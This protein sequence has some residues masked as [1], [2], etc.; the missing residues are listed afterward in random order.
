MNRDGTGTAEEMAPGQALLGWLEQV[1]EEMGRDPLEDLRGVR[2]KVEARARA[3]E[4][5]AG[6]IAQ[7]RAAP[8][9]ADRLTALQERTLALAARVRRIREEAC[10]ELN[11]Y[12]RDRRLAGSL[13]GVAEPAAAQIDCVG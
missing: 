1:D 8:W 12:G 2:S 4:Q 7:T 6:L 11:R 13:G 9:P 5:L 10:Q 3:I